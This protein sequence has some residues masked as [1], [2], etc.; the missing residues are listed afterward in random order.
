[1][2]TASGESE[3]APPGGAAQRGRTRSHGRHENGGAT[4]RGRD[5]ASH[6]AASLADFA[7][8]IRGHVSQ[9]V[10]RV[11]QAAAPQEGPAER[12]AAPPSGQGGAGS[13]FVPP[14]VAPSRASA[15]GEGSQAPPPGT[16][17][18]GSSVPFDIHQIAWLSSAIGESVAASLTAFGGRVHHELEGIRED[19]GALRF[20]HEETDVRLGRVHASL[21]ELRER[22]ESDATQTARRV[23]ELEA[24]MAAMSSRVDAARVAA[25]SGA[26]ERTIGRLGN[27]GWDT[28]PDVLETRA[29]EVLK[30][31]EVPAEAIR[32]VA[33]SVGRLGRGSAVEVS[34]A[35]AGHM[36]AA[37]VAVRALRRTYQDGRVVWL[38][39]AR[40]RAELA[41]V[42]S[43]HRLADF[44]ADVVSSEAYH[45]DR[46]A[47]RG[48]GARIARDPQRR[49]V[50]LGSERVAVVTAERVIW[51]RYGVGA[52]DEST[53][54]DGEAIAM[55]G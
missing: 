36:D 2:S 8:A 29:R 10:H 49:A 12:H 11:A 23:G 45:G 30:D 28:L 9:A 47:S 19:I 53:R 24:A 40:T 33:A 1:M 22:V 18:A 20:G 44:L 51:T 3:E 39:A 25:P 38:T 34:F 32:A 42:R 41:P 46:Q 55:S 16:S 48:T 6:A 35:T 26:T 31:A 7:A 27:L 5:P 54:A 21:A 50:S 15:G 4:P 13:P 14:H 17:A 43:M 52:F 37:A